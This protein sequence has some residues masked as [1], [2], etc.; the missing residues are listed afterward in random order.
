MKVNATQ[1]KIKRIKKRALFRTLPCIKMKTLLHITI[2]QAISADVKEITQLFYDTIQVINSKD[3]PKD[4][5]DDWSSWYKDIDKWSE[6][7]SEQFFIVA[8]F[9]GKIIGFSSLA[10]DGYLDFMFVHKDFQGQGV[11]KSL[12]TELEKKASEQ[13][14]DLIY[15]DVSITA[16]GFFEKHGFIVEKQQLKKSK[17]KELIN[18][19]MIKR[20]SD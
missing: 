19:R 1:Q 20:L 3:Y 15:S 14:N 12:L 2:S 11:A 10:I 4:E 7:L 8:K 17:K 6:K 16:R 18:Y 9:D 5:I 13:K